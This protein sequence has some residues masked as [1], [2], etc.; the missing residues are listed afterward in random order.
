MSLNITRGSCLCFKY[1]NIKLLLQGRSQPARSSFSLPLSLSLPLSVCIYSS[2]P[3]LCD[4]LDI[5]FVS[6]SDCPH[7]SGSSRQRD[8]R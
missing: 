6:V 2:P 8:A 5:L 7:G 1:L 4:M 3:R